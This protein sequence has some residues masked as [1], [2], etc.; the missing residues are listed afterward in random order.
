MPGW[1]VDTRPLRERVGGRR[2]R[3]D[4]RRISGERW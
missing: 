4:G 3:S 1:E 2:R